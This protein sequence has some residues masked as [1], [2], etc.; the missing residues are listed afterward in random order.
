MLD[1]FGLP[2]F[3]KLATKVQMSTCLAFGAMSKMKA[4][5]SA[6]HRRPVVDDFFTSTVRP[7]C[8]PMMHHALMLDAL[9]A[10]PTLHAYH[11]EHIGCN[12]SGFTD[13]CVPCSGSGFLQSEQPFQLPC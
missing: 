1:D 13:C 11:V 8:R 5:C 4:R 3:S 10:D 7:A 9:T 2:H 12:A 6:R